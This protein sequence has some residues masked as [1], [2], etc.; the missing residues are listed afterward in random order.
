MAEGC[1]LIIFF[2]EIMSKFYLKTAFSLLL[3]LDSGPFVNAQI[4]NPSFE[5]DQIVGTSKTVQK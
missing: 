2:S 3:L 5:E 4:I 1:R